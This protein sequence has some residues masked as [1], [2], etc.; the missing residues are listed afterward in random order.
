M[1]ASFLGAPRATLHATGGDSFE[2][3]P[4]S[5]ADSLDF[6]PGK[7]LGEIFLETD[8]HPSDK[9]APDFGKEILALAERVRT[10]PA[11][12]LVSVA[13]G[14][15]T[16]ARQHY[17]SGGDWCNLLH[18]VR[19]V[20]T[21]SADNKMA[22]A[23]YIKWRVENKSIF[24]SAP[25]TETTEDESASTKATAAPAE[26]EKRARN[27]A[28]ALKPHWLYLAG[29]AHYRTGDRVECLPW[30]ERV[31]K[32]FP[33]H[34]RGE[35]ALFMQARCAFSESRRG[36]EALDSRSPEE[37]TGHAPARKKAAELF[38]R[39][40]KQYPRGRFEADALG[41]L[42]A[43][44]FDGENY[45]KALEYYIAQAEVPGHP[46]TIKS[47]VFMCEKCLVRVAEK[48]DSA[49]AFAL[50]ARHPRI[51]MGF[52]Y[53]VLS[54][55]EAKNYDGKFDPPADV[56]KWRRTMMPKIAAE[57]VK[58]KQLYQAGDW[59]PRY[60]AMLAQAASAT[61][62]QEQALQL[63]NLAPAD[64]ERSDD[65]LMVRAVAFQRAGKVA[66]ALEA[67]RKFLDRFPKSP[68]APGARLR[69]AFALQDN[70]QA[71][72][73]VVELKLLL[74]EQSPA[75]TKSP[76][77]KTK[78]EDE[79]KKEE[80]P[81]S[82]TEPEKVDAPLSI[83]SGESRYTT[84]E[85]YPDNAEEWDLKESSVYPNIT[86]AE[87][88]EVQRAIDTLLNFAPLT[89][90]A[91]AVDDPAF[92]EKGRKEFRAIIAQRYLAQE[93]FAEAKKFMP[94]DEFKLLAAN[95]ET[96]TL[97]A[98][99]PPQEKAEEM[100]RLGNAW[101]DARGKLLRAPLDSVVHFLRRYS[102]LDAMQRRANGRSLRAKNVDT[103]LEERDELRHASRWWLNAARAR[104]GT[105]LGA[106]ARWKALEAMPKI[107]FASQYAEQL[108]RE[109][110]GEAVSR[111]IYEK[112]RKESP[113]S[114]EAKRLAA[115][116]SF[117]APISADDQNY[118]FAT[119][120]DARILGYPYSDFEAFG[121][122]QDDGEASFGADFM[123]RF[124][125]LVAK[126]IAAEPAAMTSIAAEAREL[127]ARA[128]KEL[129]TIYDASV[130]NFLDD[131]A[132]F[133]SEPK[134]TPEMMKIYVGIRFD[135]LDSN[136]F[137]RPDGTI[138]PEKTKDADIVAKIEAALK[139]PIM[140][141]V[142]DYLEFSLIGLKAGDRIA[143][144]TDIPDLK[145]EEGKATFTSRDHAGMEKM[146]RDF[147]KKYPKSQKREAALFVIARSVQALS[148]PY[149]CDVGTPAPGTSPDEQI[150]DIERK[151]YQREPF[152]PKRVLA[153]LDEYDREF[154]NGRY[155]AENRNLR[156]MT[157]WR[158][159]DWSRALELTLVQL[160]DKAKPD[161]HWEAA[162]RLANIFADLSNA[163]FRADIL[164]AIRSKPAAALRLKSFLA[165]VST[166][167]TH[168]L[169]YLV[170]YL[171][172]QL[173][174]NSVA[175]N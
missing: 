58:Q 79:S 49:A 28:G 82:K 141:P 17:S 72:A 85:T 99:G 38:E 157:L 169:R 59:Q 104:P 77:T 110:K 156:A 125:S 116:W 20:L 69:L 66:E 89:E 52:T 48:T 132:H 44:A 155:A 108:A 14:L 10:E 128:K 86:G 145:S 88:D 29:A 33:N 96:L 147:L 133:V 98:A 53:L 22:A 54:A 55:P 23:D 25:K 149:V 118:E 174:L 26:L 171:N 71:G 122:K 87:V 45:L 9:E 158:M 93:N 15:L 173:K 81:E 136:G 115:Y 172:D 46:E 97:A 167:R 137:S 143:V 127:D 144:S 24:F 148:R 129:A 2:A 119:T 175:S 43:L 67:Y 113:D 142:A 70:H 140:Q 138:L 131:L 56:K 91:A 6:L 146:A 27:A 34:P 120:R 160:N 57:V 18:D 165:K 40:R 162:V 19:D 7:S 124:G 166:D 103:E 139:N 60:L 95:L 31:A 35:I 134:I 151:S 76:E 92:D 16:Q 83:L 84:M 164:D 94:P 154:P 161:L 117:P 1:S 42:G 107:A 32:E 152:D 135:V 30:F 130:A 5:L 4:P 37:I 8:A 100:M 64:L 78:S 65:L 163:E 68:M 170:S 106:Q 13:D 21:H 112:L 3:P 90:L 121:V 159:H 36:I 41:W 47:A 12:Q 74:V 101:A 75:E 50:I 80:D 168:P 150:Y 62:N 114:I 153:A 63:T 51:A 111:E 11:P 126:A 123:K 105:P 61:G 102:Q 73:A 39:Y 109:I